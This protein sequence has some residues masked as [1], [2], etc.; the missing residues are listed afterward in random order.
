MFVFGA[1]VDMLRSVMAY[2][3]ELEFVG[4]VLL[5]LCKVFMVCMEL[6]ISGSV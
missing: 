2:R 1:L 3:G 4:V 6:F 5:F